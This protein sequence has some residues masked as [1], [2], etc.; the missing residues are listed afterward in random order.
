MYCQYIKL[1]L[2]YKK[3]NFINNFLKQND[4]YQK[5]KKKMHSQIILF[6]TLTNDLKLICVDMLKATP[7]YNLKNQIATK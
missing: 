7:M 3:T 2:F 4:K 6:K 5:K 1:K